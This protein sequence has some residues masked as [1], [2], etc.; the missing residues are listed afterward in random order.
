[1]LLQA[2]LLLGWWRVPDRRVATARA[3]AAIAVVHLV[4]GALLTV[5]PLPVLPFEPEQTVAH[6]VAH[7]SYGIAQLP[8]IMLGVAQRRP[9]RHDGARAKLSSGQ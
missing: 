1:V 2:V 3:L 8:S 7:A 6:Y 9:E 5:L 4:G